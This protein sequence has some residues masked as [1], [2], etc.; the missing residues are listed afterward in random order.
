MQDTFDMR[1]GNCR[2]CV[3]VFGHSLK[4]LGRYFIA[5]VAF[6]PLLSKWCTLRSVGGR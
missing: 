3:C 1:I 5:V 4:V 2:E 6:P